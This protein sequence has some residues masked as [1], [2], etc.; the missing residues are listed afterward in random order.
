MP[1]PFAIL[2]FFVGALGTL[3]LFFW[4]AV[5]PALHELERALGQPGANGAAV[6]SSTGIRHDVLVW[7]DR[8]LHQ[9]PHGSHLLHPATGEYTLPY[10]DEMMGDRDLAVVRLVHR[11]Q[12]LLVA[13]GNP[14]GITGLGDL[15]GGE[16]SDVNRQRGAGTRM[17][18][19]QELRR[20]EVDPGQ[21]R[22][23]AREGVSHVQVWID[24]STVAGVEAFASVL[25]LLDRNREPTGHLIGRERGRALV[26]ACCE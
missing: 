20:L 10:L 9:L 17:L 7:V 15:A 8:Q 6:D 5:P 14:H 19:D 3:G 11:D 21:V 2:V 13:P 4:L 26:S 24:P 16:L 23:Y 12:G 1:E 18:L 25:E 22:G